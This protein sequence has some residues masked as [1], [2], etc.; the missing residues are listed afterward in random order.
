MPERKKLVTADC[1]V[2]EHLPPCRHYFSTGSTLLDLA[3]SDRHPGGAGSGRITHIYGDNSTAKTVL[4]QEILGSCQRLGG[5]VVFED[6]ECTLDFA[7]AENLFGLKVGAWTEEGYQERML[8][9][10]WAAKKGESLVGE[11]AKDEDGVIAERFIY[12]QPDTVEELYDDE[13]GPITAMAADGVLRGP[14]AVGVDSLSA[15]TSNEEQDGR[16]EDKSFRGKRAKV[17][18]EA[19]RKYIKRIAHNDVAINGVDQTRANVGVTF[20]P[21]ETTSGGMAIRFY[22]STRILLKSAGEIKNSRD[23]VVG[24]RIKAKT[25]KNKIA[26]PLRT[27]YFSVI[28]DYGIDDV[29]ENL[30]WLKDKGGKLEQ[31]GAWFSWGDVKLGSGLEKAIRGIEQNGLEDELAAE[32]ARVWKELY[33]PD[34]R[35]PRRR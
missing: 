19:F 11:L 26:P 20:G 22:A 23:V 30:E 34:D 3:I 28:F 5:T 4:A 18:S 27:V 15:L 14:V 16:L 13:I 32:V 24:V 17:A 6:A 25:V 8:A 12:R 9:L 29:R 2:R 10:P 21:K 1:L 31:K 7:R 33:R 35:K